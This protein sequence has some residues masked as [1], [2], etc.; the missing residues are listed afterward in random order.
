[1][2][3]SS[4]K[5]R[6]FK[7]DLAKFFCLKIGENASVINKIR[8]LFFSFEIQAV[9]AFRFEQ[10]THKLFKKHKLIGLAPR[11]ISKI[12][13][14]YVHLFHHVDID[15]EADIGPGF[16]I[17][18]A[19]SIMIGPTKIG[20]NFTVSHNTTIGWG[21]AEEGDGIAIPEIGDNVWIGVGVI[22]SGKIQIGNN[23]TVSSGSVLSKSI[24]E[25]CLVAGN[26]GRVIIQNYNN[27]LQSRYQC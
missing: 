9:A 21:F 18:H 15:P 23:V 7:H 10:L 17:T 2:E 24:P 26:P 16:L 25:S 5:I 4:D 1:M 11:V 20:K 14:S 27:I 13:N 19:N 22:L 12:F 3:N 8:Q 6:Y